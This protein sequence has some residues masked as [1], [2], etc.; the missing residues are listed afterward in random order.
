[1]QEQLNQKLIET[2]QQLELSRQATAKETAKAAKL[3][4]DAAKLQADALARQQ[5][6][7]AEVSALKAAPA[8][9]RLPPASSL[10]ACEASNPWIEGDRIPLT[11]DGY[12]IL[13]GRGTHHLDDLEFAPKDGRFPDVWV[14]LNAD[15]ANKEDI[16]VNETLLW[17][18]DE[19]QSTYRRL[20]KKGKSS[21]TNHTLPKKKISMYQAPDKQIFPYA[22]KVLL[23]LSRLPGERTKANFLF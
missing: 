18:Q 19:A 8:R 11:E 20:L 21:K 23:S 12:Y 9:P 3:Q 13:P 7:E 6:W 5:A 16:N 14:R 2:Q 22:E 1:M 10:P 15:I 4:A 17:K